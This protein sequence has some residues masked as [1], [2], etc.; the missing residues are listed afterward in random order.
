MRTWLG[1]AVW[2]VALGAS[3]ELASAQDAGW[4]YSRLDLDVTVGGAGLLEV[5]GRGVLEVTADER[6]EL[7]L[8]VNTRQSAMRFESM[9][10][11]Q[12][13]ARVELAAD[14]PRHVARVALAQPLVRGD[15]LAIEFALRLQRG[16]FQLI[17]QDSLALASWV[18]AWYPI[19]LAESG[20][21]QQWAAPGR[22]RFHLPDG[23]RAV[24][25]GAVQPSGSAGDGVADEW[26]T[27]EPVYRSFAAAPYRVAQT[28]AGDRRIGVYLLRADSAAA[29]RQAEVLARAITAMEEVWGAYP[30]AGYAI[31]EIPD[32]VTSWAASSEQGF[33]MATS[34]HFG[35]DGNLPLFAHEAAHAWWGNLV[36]TTG[37]GSQLVSESLAQYG[38]VVAIEALEGR[39]AMNEFLRFSRRGYNQYQSAAGYFE[40]VRQGGDKAL[41]ALANDHW[42]HNLSD[43]KGHWF[44]HMLRHRVGDELFFGTLRR[45]LHE[46]GGRAL[47]LSDLRA[48]FIAAAPDDT[49]MAGF[50]AQWLDRT[51]A[52]AL[53]HRWWAGDRGGAA[54]IEIR[55]LQPDLYDL[56][57]TVEIELVNGHQVRHQLHIDGRSHS[58]T[59]PVHARPVDVRLDPDHVLLHWRPEYGPRPPFGDGE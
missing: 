57:L 27:A 5:R 35:D 26:H 55:Q 28:D 21:M 7:R 23:W 39:D 24:S 17:V 53:E 10:T 33:I 32:G 9:T 11:S 51:G 58:F 36:N 19:P 22:T 46:Y 29:S 2:L 16:S 3:V 52:P 41:A 47:S 44:H 13:A 43:S 1:S 40:I 45:I 59:F 8:A 6:S 14:S 34:H 25:N 38:A 37:P 4:R 18:E 31:A 49:A 42:D 20:R 30:Y 56:P 50:M 12:P 48:A 54:H 15:T